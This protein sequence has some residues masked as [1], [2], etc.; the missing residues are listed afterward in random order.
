MANKKLKVK[1]MRE[2]AQPPEC[3]NG[4]WYDCYVSQVEVVHEGKVF[5]Y[6]KGIVKYRKGDTVIIHLGFAADVGK[7]YEGHILPRSGTF[8]KYGLILTNGMGIVDDSYNGDNDEWKAW[9]FATRGGGFKIGDRLIQISLEK[10]LPIDID[11][12]SEL[13]NPDRGGY[14]STGE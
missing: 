7:G 3:H 14:G 2:N 10:S 13:G 9:M 1:L 12:I 6:T 11:V 5:K 8:K 4:N